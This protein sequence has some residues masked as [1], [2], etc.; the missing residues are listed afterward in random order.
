MHLTLFLH[1]NGEYGRPQK[2]CKNTDF[3]AWWSLEHGR[4]QND[5]KYSDLLVEWRAWKVPESFK[6]YRLVWTSMMLSIHEHYLGRTYQRLLIPTAG[7]TNTPHVNAS[8]A[9]LSLGM[10]YVN[11]STTN[12]RFGGGGKC[13]RAWQ[14]A[15]VLLSARWREAIFQNSICVV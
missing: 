12:V 1:W 4:R 7:C 2:H 14:K 9:D 11:T 3:F 13:Y 10:A 6:I 8:C 5:H 15:L